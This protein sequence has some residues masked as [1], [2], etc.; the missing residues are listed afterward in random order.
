MND[1][2]EKG[3]TL[4]ALAMGVLREQEQYTIAQLIEDY[5]YSGKEL[6]AEGEDFVDF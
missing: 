6:D 4:L 1:H 5:L 2:Y 3:D